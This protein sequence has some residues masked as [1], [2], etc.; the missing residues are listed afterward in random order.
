MN[1][2]TFGCLKVLNFLKA[3]FA[4]GN[5]GFVLI[6]D[7]FEQSKLKIETELKSS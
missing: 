1:F 5:K 7:E 6:V 2:N 4:K 3:F